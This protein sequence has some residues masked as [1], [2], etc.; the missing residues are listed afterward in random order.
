MRPVYHGLKMI[1]WPDD[2]EL[3]SFP[4]THTALAEPN[5]FLAYGGKVSPLWLD[6]AYRRGIFPWNSPDSMRQWWSPAP[7]AVILPEHFRIPRTLRKLLKRNRPRLTCNLAFRQV[8]QACA[9]ERTYTQGTWISEEM[10]ESYTRLHQA[11]RAFSVE[12]WGEDGALVGGFYGLIIGQAVFGES[13]FSRASNASKLAFAVFA[14]HL[15]NQG[16][17]FID[18]QMKT[19]HLAQFGLVELAR[20]DF[21]RRLELAISAPLIKLDY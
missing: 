2:I 16:A 20:N 18:C 3:P 8:M 14:P 19:D 12:S 1:D 5:G 13:M 7:R 9:S 6:Q 11:G 15:F 17:Q 4:A 10:I 21:E